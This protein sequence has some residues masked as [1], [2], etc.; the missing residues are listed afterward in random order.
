VDAAY[1]RYVVEAVFGW[2]DERRGREVAI[3]EKTWTAWALRG[4]QVVRL[5][6]VGSEGEPMPVLVLDEESRAGESLLVLPLKLRDRA[7][8]AVVLTAKYGALRPAATRVL[9]ILVNQ[10]AAL[11]ATLQL[12]ER[13]KEK[14]LHDPLTGLFN[15]RA[16]T[17]HLAHEMARRDRQGGTLALLM[18]DLDHFKKLN[19]TH[20]H[21]AGDA[22]LKRSSELL[23]RCLRKGD[24]A[25]RYGGEEFVVMLAG[26]DE[27]VALTIAE[28]IRSALEHA[29]IEFGGAKIRVTASVGLAVWPGHGRTPQDL[30]GAADRALYTAKGAGRNRVVP[31]P[32]VEIE[33]AAPPL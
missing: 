24:V 21:P 16:F 4:T 8:G 22:A 11:L 19:D 3:D 10:A 17:D 33:P 26:A 23:G 13:M 9:E 20:G 25:A 18:L 2:A 6:Q 1:T 28:R 7:L 12:A 15:R 30:L 29:E 31:A 32:P 5:D 14:A 27:E